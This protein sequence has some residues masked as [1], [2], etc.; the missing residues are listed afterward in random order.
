MYLP[1]C[2][3]S[4]AALLFSDS[5]F[6]SL[7]E[8]VKSLA[9][10]NARRAE[11]ENDMEEVKAQ[12][13]S[14][15]TK[16]FNA[17]RLFRLEIENGEFQRELDLYK[18]ALEEAR[19]QI[20]SNA[21]HRHVELPLE[22]ESLR[23]DLRAAESAVASAEA[24]RDAAIQELQRLRLAFES[25]KIL[26]DSQQRRL[27]DDNVSL[28]SKL[29]TLPRLVRCSAPDISELKSDVG[30]DFSSIFRSTERNRPFTSQSQ[31]YCDSSRQRDEKQTE[32]SRSPFREHELQGKPQAHYPCQRQPASSH[33]SSA[34]SFSAATTASS[35]CFFPVQYASPPQ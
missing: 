28:R 9:L 12:L 25:F 26:A 17:G 34:E 27:L 35:A 31:Q 1:F 24:S 33:V 2:S 15:K 23:R 3:L 6:S 30:I 4:V 16:D 29:A 19:Q 22:I 10:S 20:L 32:H 5:L 7:A 18:S 11:L 21:Q 13:R 14:A 8:A